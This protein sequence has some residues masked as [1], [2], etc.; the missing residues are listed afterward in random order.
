[1]NGFLIF[2]LIVALPFIIPAIIY[3]GSY[4]KKRFDL[5]YWQYELSQNL[6]HRV[7]EDLRHWERGDKVYM[8]EKG[9]N[10]GNR[11]YYFGVNDDKEL[12]VCSHDPEMDYTRDT[13]TYKA[14]DLAELLA[15]YNVKNKAAERRIEKSETEGL[16]AS[17]ENSSYWNFFQTYQEQMDL[18]ERELDNKL[19]LN[20]FDTID[21]DSVNQPQRTKQR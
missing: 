19:E 1:M 4:A 13:Q 20:S 6:P 2:I 8:I 14:Y 10:N 5:L 15:F 11:Y 7:W 18:I 12:V 3:G 17:V 9:E 16:K 21:D